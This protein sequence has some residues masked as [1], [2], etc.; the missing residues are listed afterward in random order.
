[1]ADMAALEARLEELRARVDAQ[2]RTIQT[3]V[4]QLAQLAQRDGAKPASPAPASGGLLFSN[5][6]T[7]RPPQP[8]RGQ[9]ISHLSVLQALHT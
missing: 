1:M 5:W 7:V 9:A 8:A 4:A 3:L 6:L 2:E